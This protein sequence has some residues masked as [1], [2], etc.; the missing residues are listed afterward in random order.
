LLT[1]SGVH[2]ELLDELKA[3]AIAGNMEGVLALAN[4]IRQRTKKRIV[5]HGTRAD[6]CKK[7]VCSIPAN[8]WL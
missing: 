6:S 3:E 7:H 1:L 5:H 8:E 2:A 4:D